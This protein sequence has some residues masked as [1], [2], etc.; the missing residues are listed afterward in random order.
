[1]D[2]NV[3]PMGQFIDSCGDLPEF[4]LGSDIVKVG[5]EQ[6]GD[7]F[8]QV[9][10]GSDIAV[11]KPRDIP[12]KEVGIL[13]KHAAQGQMDNQVR[14]QPD[15]SFGIQF[16]QFHPG[17]DILDV[18]RVDPYLPVV[19]HPVYPGQFKP[20]PDHLIDKKIYELD[21]I[22]VVNPFSHVQHTVQSRYGKLVSPGF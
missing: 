8:C 14:Q 6:P 22:G 11:K 13:D 16:D 15:R 7:L 1:M 3:P 10:C 12:R 20:Q 5:G 18:G 17:P 4:T 21:I 9:V 2:E 19:S